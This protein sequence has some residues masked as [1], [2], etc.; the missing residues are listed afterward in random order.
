MHILVTNDDGP[1]STAASPYILPFVRALERA[2][3]TV[4]VIIPDSQRSWIGKAHLVGQDVVAT[5]YWPPPTNP[6][7]HS[8]S[9]QTSNG[10]DGSGGEAESGD[11]GKG[12]PWILVNS[13]PA[14][15]AQLGLS[16]YFFA[17]PDDRPI[18]LV[19]SGPNYGR[20]TTAV[21]ALSSGTLGAALEAAVCGAKAIALSFAFFDRVTGGEIVEEACAHSVRVCEELAGVKGKVEWGDGRL[22][23]VN[24][25][26]QRGV[27]GRAVRWTR[28]LQNRWEQGACF[29][30][31]GG[32]AGTEVEGAEK[33]EVRLRRG[34][35]GGG[36]GA[37][38]GS[39]DACTADSQQRRWKARHFKWAPRFT[40]V[41]ES[42][43]RAG[44][45]TDGWAVKEG[46]TSITAIRANFMHA[47]PGEGEFKL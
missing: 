7:V 46:E 30:E 42:V 8:P 6:D 15:C 14:S 39:A 33:E 34:E 4:S 16:K 43:Q 28:M 41:Y 17:S 9:N 21:F 3:H 44:P 22:Y 25:P 47:G 19:V 37:D 2:G 18:D 5:A 31:V 26:L 10:R 12:K 1:P 36:K 38:G 23:S 29:Q 32:G 20:N 35:E 24:V 27:S 40:D 45:G 13:T 11:E